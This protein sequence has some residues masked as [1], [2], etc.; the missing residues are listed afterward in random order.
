[1][2]AQSLNMLPTHPSHLVTHPLRFHPAQQSTPLARL[3]TP[4]PHQAR[5]R[6]TLRALLWLRAPRLNTT[7]LP[8][9]APQ[10]FTLLALPWF[11]APRLSTTRLPHQAPQSVTLLAL[12]WL[13]VPSPLYLTTLLAMYRAALSLTDRTPL[14][15]PVTYPRSLLQ[16]ATLSTLT[17]SLV[18]TPLPRPLSCPAALRWLLLTTPRTTAHGSPRRT[19]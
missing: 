18:P 3:C 10:R 11:R 17:M 6:L 16:S 2:L 4:L 1:L 5:Q 8:R 12:P 14:V 9:R 15:T 7:R 13:R 19:T